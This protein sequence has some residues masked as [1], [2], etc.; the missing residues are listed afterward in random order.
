MRTNFK[1]NV[2]KIVCSLLGLVA[3]LLFLCGCNKD[4]GTFYSLDEAYENGWLTK[5]DLMEICYYRFGEVYIGESTDS[6]TWV[7]YE[8]NSQNTLSELDKTVENNIKEAYYSLHKSDFF[9]RDGKS[10]GGI[11]NLSV[12]YCGMY[13]NSYVVVI[14]CSLWDT[15]DDATPR[16]LSGVAWWE[17]GDGFLVY[18]DK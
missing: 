13:N 11:D 12:Q 10:L 5:D 3:F 14:E 17:T 7:R 15:G 4:V 2:K 8:Y 1:K 6:D 18:R 9:D 16:H